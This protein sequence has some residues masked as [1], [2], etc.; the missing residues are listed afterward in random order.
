MV[1]DPLAGGAVPALD[2]A[3]ILARTPGLDTIAD[4]IP[5]DRGMTPASHWTFGRLIDLAGDLRALTADPTIDGVVLVQGT[6]TIEESSLAF[7]LLVDT[8]KPIVV[9]GAMRNATDPGYD[10]PANLRDAVRCAADPQL[11]GSGVVVVLGGT[12]EPAD[13]VTKVHTTSLATFQQPEPRTPRAGRRRSGD[14]RAGPRSAAP[15]AHDLAGRPADPDRGRDDRSGRR[16]D[17]GG[18]GPRSGRDRGRSDRLGQHLGGPPG[19]GRGG[20]PRRDSD[21]PGQPQPVGPDRDRATPFPAG[22]PPGCAP[23]HFCREP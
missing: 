17:P 13:D 1:V 8:L 19:R 5:V 11:S 15:G 18:P 7:E 22:E 20:D 12:I 21:R 6:D 23:G 16:P 10:G 4:L 9:T 3:A 2:G 14:R